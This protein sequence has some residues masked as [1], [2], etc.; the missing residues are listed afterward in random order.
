MDLASFKSNLSTGNKIL[1]VIWGIAWAC[2]F[3]PTPRLFHP[4]RRFLLRFFG[5]RVGRGV[6]IDASARIFYPPHLTL[7][8]YVVIG[9]RAD[10][11]CVAPVVI[12][13]NSMI[14]QDSSLC[15]ATHDY[16]RP[17]LPLVALPITIGERSWV[18]ARAFVGPGVTIG[19][20]VVVAACAVVVKDVA[21]NRIVGGNPA[22]LIKEPCREPIE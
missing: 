5:A 19:S 10:L 6:R 20:D 4:W 11:Y 7:G 1:R 16:K 15:A 22:T 18:C 2:L 14:S 17:D 8:D 12:G 3:R 21:D 13:R 9:P